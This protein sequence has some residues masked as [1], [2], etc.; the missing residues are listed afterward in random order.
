[1]NGTKSLMAGA[2]RDVPISC[3]LVS[4]ARLSSSATFH[5]RPGEPETEAPNQMK[6][7]KSSVR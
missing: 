7:A 3:S 6:L 1:M 5:W 4:E 2:R